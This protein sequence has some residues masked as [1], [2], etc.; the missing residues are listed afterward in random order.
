MTAIATFTD[1]IAR[2]RSLVTLHATLSAPQAAAMP[3][4]E[5]LL[6]SA[7][8]FAVAGMDAYFTDRFSE[9]LVKFLKKNKPPSGLVK[10][11]AEAGLDTRTALE[12][13][14]MDRPYRRVRTLVE[15]HL[16]DYTTQKQHVID[17]LF[18]VYS[19]KDLST[20]AARLAKK[21]TLL[22]RVEYAVKRRHA[23]VHRGDLN[24]HD[25]RRGLPHKVVTKCIDSLELYVQKCE[26]LLAMA[27]KV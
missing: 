14:A 6:R 10:F 21:K 23:V 24:A 3:D 8:V 9:S 26:E 1:T 20:H 2:A 16:S 4:P 25:K 17:E 22:T 19:V 27:I 18:L 15:D 13:L 5:D 12:M 7:L 11:L